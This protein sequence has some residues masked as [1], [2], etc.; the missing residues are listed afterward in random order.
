MYI[1]QS[2]LLLVWKHSSKE[3]KRNLNVHFLT[4]FW[5]YF[6]QIREVSNFTENKNLLNQ[7]TNFFAAKHF[8][9]IWVVTHQSLKLQG[10]KPSSFV[11]MLWIS[12]Q[13]VAIVTISFSNNLKSVRY[14]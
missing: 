1:V 7:D 10:S 2:P 6:D 5:A 8:T 14:R 3:N 9:H 12:M 11:C 13:S 4:I